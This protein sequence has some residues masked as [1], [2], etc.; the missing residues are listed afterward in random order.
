M[1]DAL[2]PDQNAPK[3]RKRV[4]IAETEYVLTAG[5][6]CLLASHQDL[7]VHGVGCAD[8]REFIRAVETFRPDV[9]IAEQNFIVTNIALLVEIVMRYPPL[10][11]VC[12]NLV[13][14]HLHV[15]DKRLI[16]IEDYTDFFAVIA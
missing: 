16:R 7:E 2:T 13:D 11:L 6:Q 14:N 5:L 4:L 3:T 15:Y 8:T 9:I 1:S 12:L 10:R